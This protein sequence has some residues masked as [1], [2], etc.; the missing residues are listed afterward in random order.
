MPATFRSFFQGLAASM[1]QVIQIMQQREDNRLREQ[2]IGIQKE[3]VQV[4][5][6]TLKED[7]R[8][9]EDT[10]KASIQ[11]STEATVASTKRED[12]RLRLS[13][14]RGEL[15]ADLLRLQ[16][17]AAEINLKYQ[18]QEKID[19]SKRNQAE[20]KVLE[21]QTKQVYSAI[22][23]A[24]SR[25]SLNQQQLVSMGLAQ[26]DAAIDLRTKMFSA[27]AAISNDPEAIKMFTNDE[28]KYGTLEEL[29]AAIAQ[30]G[31]SDVTKAAVLGLTG[32]I[33]SAIQ[34]DFQMKLQ[35]MSGAKN[36]R[37]AGKYGT[38][39]DK[40]SAGVNSNIMGWYGF[41]AGTDKFYGTPEPEQQQS[42]GTGGGVVGGLQDINRGMQP[43]RDLR[44]RAGTASTIG[45]TKLYDIGLNPPY[46]GRNR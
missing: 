28:G 37:E 30:S 3:S 16:K 24:S 12:E 35:F 33:V 4:Q 9:Y 5:K 11:A 45:L 22:A 14:E 17:Q 20:L 8:R 1:P 44:G 29:G 6:D 10:G 21:A 18:E 43:L 38:E 46:G 39:Y 36:V 42:G 2:Q 34:N 23:E 40:I 15:E 26:Q 7:I 41:S 13:K 32:P 19:E 31:M 27:M 25:I